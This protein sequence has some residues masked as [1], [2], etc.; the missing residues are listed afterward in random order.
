MQRRVLA[1]AAVLAAVLFFPVQSAFGSS[2]AATVHGGLCGTPSREG[3]QIIISA[4]SHMCIERYGNFS[5]P[6]IGHLLWFDN[7]GGNE[8]WFY[9]DSN[10]K[11]WADC[12]SPEAAFALMGRDQN[13]GR[14]TSSHVTALCIYNHQA[15]NKSLRECGSPLPPFY[16]FGIP[17]KGSSGTCMNMT[18]MQFKHKPDFIYLDNGTGGPLWLYQRAN[19]K[20]W[21]D[22]L[23]YGYSYHVAGTRDADPGL[24]VEHPDTGGAC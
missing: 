12:F 17:A 19:K 11:G 6:K 21:A 16:A 18:N 5:N 2:P 10:G 7:R 15:K 22:C 20:G 4:K 24:I 14:I 1:L 3:F 8:V 9:Q 23:P 13:P